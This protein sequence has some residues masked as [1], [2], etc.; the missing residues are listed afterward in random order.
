MSDDT[1]MANFAQ[2]IVLMKQCNVNPII[3]HGG[4]PMINS[5]LGKLNITSTFHEGKRITTE[6]IMEVVEM[7]LSGKV[8]K[9][10]LAALK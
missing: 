8:N 6:E 9:S 7:V 10:I 5:A 3:V 4:G 1:A 2:D